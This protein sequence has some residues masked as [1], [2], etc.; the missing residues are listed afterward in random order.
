MGDAIE[1]ANRPPFCFR[2][3]PL[4][5]S[6]RDI[7]L[8]GRRATSK[9]KYRSAPFTEYKRTDKSLTEPLGKQFENKITVR[10]EA[11]QVAPFNASLTSTMHWHIDRPPGDDCLSWQQDRIWMQE[12]RKFRRRRDNR[13]AKQACN[14]S[15]GKCM[16]IFTAFNCQRINSL[17]HHFSFA[18]R[19]T[20]RAGA[21]NPR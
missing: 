2:A 12:S 15:C 7:Y 13:Q 17:T 18:R 5:L 19:L 14:T 20:I 3:Y 21:R 11:S 4:Y 16:P 9:D 10:R 1:I 8:S 6:M